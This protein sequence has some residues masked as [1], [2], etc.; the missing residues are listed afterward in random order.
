VCD[1]YHAKFC[2]TSLVFKPETVID[3]IFLMGQKYRAILT[4]GHDSSS[5]KSLLKSYFGSTNISFF[6]NRSIAGKVGEAQ[7][8]DPRVVCSPDAK[9]NE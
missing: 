1:E 2:T 8:Y 9:Q 6:I 7:K 5:F 4:S 3:P